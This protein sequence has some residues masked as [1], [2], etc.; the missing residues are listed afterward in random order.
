[1]F[2]IWCEQINVPYGPTISTNEPL[3]NT[4]GL[5][6]SYKVRLNVFEHTE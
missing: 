1:M 2:K 6:T 4:Y 5:K 3:L